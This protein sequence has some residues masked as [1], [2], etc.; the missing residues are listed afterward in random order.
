MNQGGRLSSFDVVR[1]IC[2]IGIIIN[3]FSFLVQHVVIW[4]LMEIHKPDNSIEIAVMLLITI[5]A[6]VFISSFFYKIKN[7]IYISRIFKK[8][9]KFF[10][11]S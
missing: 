2:A 11:L 4:F 6:I 1:A 7:V 9:D 5:C 3:H 8:I 10:A